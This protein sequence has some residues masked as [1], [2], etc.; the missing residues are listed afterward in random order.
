MSLAPG[1][2][3]AEPVRDAAH[4]FRAILDAMARPGTVRRLPCPP[5]PPGLSPAAAAVA[6]TLADADAPLWLAPALRNPATE[7]FLRFH[8]SAA[9]AAAPAEALFLLGPWAALR[10]LA[11]LSVGTPEYPDR[12]ATLIVEAESLLEGSGATLEGPGV[13]GARRL[14][15]GGADAAFWALLARNRLSYPLG[16]DV[17]LTCGETVAALPRT[18]TAHV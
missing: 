2:G 4:A 9:P 1:L 7:A 13:R 17:I 3:F 8:T 5:A 12:S 10:D 18:V 15:V 6:L 16:L 14:A 11:G